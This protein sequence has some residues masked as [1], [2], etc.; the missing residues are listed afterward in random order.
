MW[1]SLV[2]LLI[3]ALIGICYW[4]R[5]PLTLPPQAGVVMYL[6]DYVR[7]ESGFIGTPAQV[8]PAERRILP[9]DTEFARKLYRDFP[10]QDEIYCSIVLTGA[11][12][13]SIHRPE[14]CLV[15]Q[16]WNIVNQEYVPIQLKSG[17]ELVVCNLT[18][19]RV[20]QNRG[21]PL[22]ITDYDMYWFVGEKI[23]TPSHLKRA[24][25]TSWDRI[26]HNR[27]HRWAYITV[28]AQITNNLWP[29][30]LDPVQTRNL[31]IEF[32]R[33]VVPSFEKEEMPAAAP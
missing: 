10:G 33:N 12:Q 16:G 7:A 30:G 1:R 3:G 19:Q 15:A 13:Q 25:L 8:T 20:L 17:H 32:I 29:G 11:M 18:I 4:L 26:F 9:K 5:P 6:P 23:T 14:V 28:Q 24:F 31:M 27:A 22:T 2:V 21:R